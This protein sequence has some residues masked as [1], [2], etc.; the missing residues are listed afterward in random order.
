MLQRTYIPMVTFTLFHL[1]GWKNRWW[2]FRQM[3]LY[4]PLLST[5]DGLTF[6]KMVGS[7][8]GNGFSILPDLGLYGLLAVWADEASAARFFAED[9]VFQE[10]GQ[11]GTYQTFF[12]QTLRSHGSWD[13]ANP[14]PETAASLRADEPVAVI[15]R[16]SI[17]RKKLWQFWRYVPPVSASVA[18]FRQDL[19]LAIGIG[20]LPL[21]QQATFSIWRSADAMRRYAYQSAAHEDV[22]RQTHRNEWYSESL[23]ARFRITG[24]SGNGKN[25]LSEN[26]YPL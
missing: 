19:L 6:S 2:A 1:E 23:F 14:F 24:F 18:D 20:E 25:I 21:I 22:I 10:F 9:A 13:G 5:A 16:A 12:L 4:P 7:G 15:T 17:R 8:A 26:G 11:R 3:G